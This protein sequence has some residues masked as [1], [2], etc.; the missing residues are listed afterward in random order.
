MADKDPSD[1]SLEDRTDQCEVPEFIGRAFGHA[2]LIDT[3]YALT[4]DWAPAHSRDDAPEDIKQ[5]KRLRD[6]RT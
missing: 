2:S 1:P 4:Q 6:L 3:Q 5:S